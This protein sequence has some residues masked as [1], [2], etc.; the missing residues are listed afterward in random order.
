MRLVGVGCAHLR[1]QCCLW[2]G[3]SICLNGVEVGHQQLCKV[4]IQE[5]KIFRKEK[6]LNEDNPNTKGKLIR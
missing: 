6:N 5:I 2:S 1:E 4:V 3:H